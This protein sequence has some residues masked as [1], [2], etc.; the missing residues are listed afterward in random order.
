M[1]DSD[2]TVNVRFASLNRP[3]SFDLECFVDDI[4]DPTEVIICPAGKTNEF[5]T[6][7]IKSDHDWSFTL[8]ECR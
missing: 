7:W 1:S 8:E 6:E 4:E 2:A 5:S 3:P